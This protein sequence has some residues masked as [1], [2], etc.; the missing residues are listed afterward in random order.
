MYVYAEDHSKVRDINGIGGDS[1]RP[2]SA[3]YLLEEGSHL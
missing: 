3:N 1:N 2:C